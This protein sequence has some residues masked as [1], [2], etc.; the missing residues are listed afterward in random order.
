VAD[1]KDTSVK[2]QDNQGCEHGELHGAAQ[3][4]LADEQARPAQPPPTAGWPERVELAVALQQR[5]L[6]AIARPD[7]RSQRQAL[8]PGGGS[9]ADLS[10]VFPGTADQLSAVR[11]FVRAQLGDH[12]A[13][14]DAVQAA[15]GLAARAITQTAS[16]NPGGL[17]LVHVT[18]LSS[19]HAAVLVT[20]QGARQRQA[21]RCRTSAGQE[22]GRCPDIVTVITAVSGPFGGCSMRTF[23]AITRIVTCPS[24]HPLGGSH[25]RP[26][27]SPGSSALCHGVSVAGHHRDRDHQHCA[28]GACRRLARQA[29]SQPETGRPD[30]MRS[31][32]RAW[33]LSVARPISPG[34]RMCRPDWYLVLKP[35]RDAVSATWRSGAGTG[36][37]EHTAALFAAIRAASHPPSPA[38]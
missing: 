10:G 36:S 8:L 11:R 19:A 7:A 20:D 25:A 26:L 13:L 2:A 29:R 27:G 17:F 5:Y 3:G 32:P 14:G 35:V 38:S 18:A 6:A 37:A 12:P 21:S 24:A 31:R 15:S 22:P 16:G 23:L 9:A 28:P 30:A 33:Q 34:R 4:G 1:V